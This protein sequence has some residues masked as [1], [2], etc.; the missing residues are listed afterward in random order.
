MITIVII[1]RHLYST[2]FIQILLNSILLMTSAAVKRGFIFRLSV[3]V[4]TPTHREIFILINFRHRLNRPMTSLT[5]HTLEQ[6]SR[7]IEVHVVWQHMHPHPL[8]G[9]AFIISLTQLLNGRLSG[10]HLRMT[11]HA[12]TQRRNIRMPS[13]FHLIVAILAL[14]FMSADMKGMVKGDRLIG[15]IAFVIPNSGLKFRTPCEE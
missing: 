14:N 12:S 6:M 2:F 5:V 7:V 11:V 1:V 9:C 3:A 13:S 10:G 15:S 4:Y 8:D